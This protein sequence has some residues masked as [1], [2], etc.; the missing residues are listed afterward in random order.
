MQGFLIRRWEPILPG[1][2]GTSALARGATLAARWL[3]EPQPISNHPVGLGVLYPAGRYRP[4]GYALLSP[5][6]WSCKRMEVFLTRGWERILRRCGGTSALAR[7]AT[8]AVR[9]LHQLQPISNQPV[10]LRFTL[11][12]G[13]YRL[14]GY[15]FSSLVC[16]SCRDVEGFLIWAWNLILP[17]CCG[18]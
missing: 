15:P 5:G 1:C 9:W 10:G 14:G 17:G 16:W 11:R 4:G 12:A 13:G 8:L 2:G 3:N 6:C 7:G 18:T